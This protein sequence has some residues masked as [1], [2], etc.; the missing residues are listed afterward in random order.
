MPSHGPHP[1]LTARGLC[2]VDIPAVLSLPLY[3]YRC[4]QMAF[5]PREW[6]KR[7][8]AKRVCAIY[9]ETEI[10]AALPS[11]TRHSRLVFVNSQS[12]KTCLV[13]YCRKICEALLPCG[14]PW[15]RRLCEEYDHRQGLSKL[16]SAGFWMKLNRTERYTY[17]SR[18]VY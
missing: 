1:P 7:V 17:I 11:T 15:P 12:S 9:S 5:L 14:L 18:R 10:T 16:N 13:A 6:L 4:F 8:E 3:K 2:G